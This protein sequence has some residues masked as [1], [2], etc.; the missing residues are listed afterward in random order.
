MGRFY[1]NTN[2]LASH[3]LADAVD[4]LADLGYAG[5]ALTPD[6]GHLDPYAATTAE[7]DAF[8]A[9]LARRGLGVVLETGA[10]FVLDPRRKHRPSLLDAPAEAA[11][12]LD[13][14]VRC[15]DLAERLGAPVVS[16][17]AGQGPEDL[18]PAR[19]WERLV[20]GVRTLCAHA[21][22][23]GVR[24]GFEPEPGM[25]VERAEG[26]AR[27][28][29]A[30]GHPALGLTLDVGHC[31]ATGEGPPEEILRRHAGDLLVVQLDD[32]R[33]GVHEHLM[34]GAGQVDFGAVARA[35]RAARFEGPLEV[36]LSRHSAVA[37]AAAAE[38]IAFLRRAFAPE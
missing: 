30:V 5:I 8:A 22:A 36:E 33:P 10:R 24:V 34:F 16:I 14:L 13:Y 4:L 2:G 23:R 18:A 20:G 26:Y 21:A 3:R 12:R 38:S 7:V 19:A 15:V 9:H 17:W 31:L 29:A 35:L 6:V 25:A 32:H 27:L 11:R 37:P 28:W 1:Y